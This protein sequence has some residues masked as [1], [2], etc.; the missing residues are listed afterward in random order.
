MVISMAY[1]KLTQDQINTLVAQGCTAQEWSLVTVSDGFDPARVRN[2]CFLGTVRIGD[3]RGTTQL[4]QRLEK[5]NG[6][7]Q[8]TLIDCTVGNRCRIANVGAHIACYDI[9]EQVCIEDVGLMQTFPD[10][11]F[12]NGTEV[13]VLNEAG[14]R[15]VILFDELS[16]QFAYMMCMHR[17][18]PRVIEKL[19]TMALDY[20]ASVRS[21]RGW[22]GPHAQIRFVKEIV[23]VKVGSWAAVVGASTLQNG[24]ILS[25]EEGPTTVG[26]D[27]IAEDF[28]IAEG[29]CVDSGAILAKVFVG[30]GCQV[31]KQ[32]SA[33]NSLFFANCEAFH[34]EAVSIFAGPYTVT[35][36]KSTLLIAGL[37][38]FYNAGSGSNQSNHMYKLGPVHEGK[39]L[40][41]SKTGSFSYMMWPCRVG[42][43]SVVLGKHSSTFDTAD[44]PFSHLEAQH[45]GKCFMV[46]GLHLT[47]VGT[48][49]DG[50]KWPQRDRREGMKKRDILSFD[51][52][53]PYTIGKMI[54]ASAQLKAL[55]ESTDKSISEV[56]IG[57]ALV[58]RLIL[59]TSQKYYRT[60]IEMYLQEKLVDRIEAGLPL[61]SQGQAGEEWIDLGGQMMPKGRLVSLWEAVEGGTVTNVTDFQTRLETIHDSYRDDEWAWARQA[62][63]GYFGVDIT[64]LSEEGKRD[65]GAALLRV[66]SKFLNLVAAD[67]GKEFGE[68]SQVGF[69]QDGAAEDL[70]VDF[71]GVRGQQNDNPFIKDLKQRLEQLKIRVEGLNRM[72]DSERKI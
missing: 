17:F 70:L 64:S 50:A 36:H 18:R 31:G 59:R 67:A 41:G 24:T 47:T 66:K 8:A 37:F 27:V 2:V 34:G 55:Q 35:H 68:M 48:V 33:E 72:I 49:R 39:L 11:P 7:Y 25:S 26:T 3:L 62:Y 29:S 54:E 58:K 9:A 4:S 57:G 20:A 40:R 60:G 19:N 42:P 51:V 56:S 6:I 28:I 43:F 53:C 71:A 46:P 5:P 69:G 63:E 22:V 23:N 10:S 52:F 44:Y 1:K 14:G 45:N 12:G 15:E 65:A 16:S 13:A 32:F 21:D 38:S 30:Q 61:D